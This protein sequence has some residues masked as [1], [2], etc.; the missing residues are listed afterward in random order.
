MDKQSYWEKIY[1]T[2]KPDAVSWYCPHLEKSRE[3]IR[4]SAISL[5]AAIID[6]GGGAST[7]VDDLLKEGFHDITVL[8]IS[9]AAIETTKKRL[10]KQAN[11]VTWVTADI[12]ETDLP[13]NRYDVWHDRAVFH[14]LTEPQQRTA[15]I[16]QVLLAVKPGGHVI[17]ATFG[18]EGP[19]KCSGLNVMRYDADALHDAFGAGFQLEDSATLLHATPFGTTQQFVYCLF[20]MG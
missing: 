10:G 18:P 5:S 6:V 2:K 16:R 3:L 15:Y 9:A 7:L 4:R 14:F 12:T 19:L 1:Q 11:Q 20:K 13:K 17:I 8:D